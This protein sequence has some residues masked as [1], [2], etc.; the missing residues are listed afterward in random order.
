[1]TVSTPMATGLQR[2]DMRALALTVIRG[3]VGVRKRMAQDR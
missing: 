2:E 1:M 3:S